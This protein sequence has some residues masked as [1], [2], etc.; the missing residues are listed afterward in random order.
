MESNARL[1]GLGRKP[2]LV[3]KL[4]GGGAG[5]IGMGAKIKACAMKAKNLRSYTKPAGS[6]LGDS[7]AGVARQEAFKLPE[8]AGE[9]FG[10]PI[11]AAGAIHRLVQSPHHDAELAAVE[12][13]GLIDF[14]ESAGGRKAAHEPIQ[15]A[16][17][18]R[19]MTAGKR[20]QAQ[21][22]PATLVVV[23][24]NALADFF[25]G[26]LTCGRGDVGVAVP[27]RAYPRAKTQE[28]A[29]VRKA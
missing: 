11:G 16:L 25:G 10:K 5:S 15:V 14:P 9:F 7:R 26:I 2:L 27:V 12:F 1:E 6:Q 8:V 24:Q 13:A 4:V 23:T 22:A 3:Q 19:N 20:C 29:G 28:R 21:H 18:F 17:D